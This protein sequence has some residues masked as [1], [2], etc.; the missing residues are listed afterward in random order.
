MMCIVF[1]LGVPGEA[2]G[3]RAWA[4]SGSFRS[5]D[6]VRVVV[7]LRTTADVR[8]FIDDMY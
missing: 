1:S 7:E 5:L 3:V 2:F 4:M 8:L 6:D